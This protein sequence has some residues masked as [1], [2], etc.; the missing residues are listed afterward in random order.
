MQKIFVA[1]LLVIFG[2]SA[3]AQSDGAPASPKIQLAQ[4]VVPIAPGSG[5]VP[6]VPLTPPSLAPGSASYTSCQVTCGTQV[7]ACQSQCLSL[8]SGASNSASITVV[9]PT[10]NA[11][12]CT[13]N[14]T[15]QQLVCQQSCARQLSQ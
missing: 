13:L 5:T 15:T 4:V 14:C 11:T 10:T 7:Q 12:Q 9:G 6:P 1:L 8:A 3:F 2:G